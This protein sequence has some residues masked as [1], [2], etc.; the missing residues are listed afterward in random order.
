MSDRDRDRER[1]R[2]RDRS[3]DR[4]RD[5]S[6]ERSRERDRDSRDARDSR[7]SDGELKRRTDSSSLDEPKRQNLEHDL[8]AQS[9]LRPGGF[10]PSVQA[11]LDSCF[12]TGAVKICLKPWSR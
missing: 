1:D 11:L 10:L 5:R 7:H 6:R 8:S 12:A 2:D 4:D 9:M 3:R